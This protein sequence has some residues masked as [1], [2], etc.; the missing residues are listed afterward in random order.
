MVKQRGNISRGSF[1]IPKCGLVKVGILL[2]WVIFYLLLQ[3]IH[4]MRSIYNVIIRV[5]VEALACD[6]QNVQILYMTRQAIY[7]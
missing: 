7:D 1:Q 4:N 6:D 2:I 5:L 3:G